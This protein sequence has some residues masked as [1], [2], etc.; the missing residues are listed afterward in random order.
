MKTSQKSNW[1]YNAKKIHFEAEL[2]KKE[3][4]I[5]WEIRKKAK[6]ENKKGN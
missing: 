5:Q 3:M 1:R 2:I 4:Q 6:E